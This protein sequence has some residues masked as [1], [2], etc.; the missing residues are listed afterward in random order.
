M[1]QN[2]EDILRK[3][4]GYDTFRP[5][6]REIIG[7][8]LDGRDTIAL[9]PTGGGKSLTYQVPALCSEGVAIVV[10]PLIALMK[11][12]V[13]TLRRLG[14][15]AVAINSAMS[16]REI[17]IALD[18]CVY[19]DVKLL[20][21]APERIDTVIFRQRVRKMNVSLIAIDEAHCI[22][23]WGYDFRPSYLKISTLRDLLPGVPVLAVTATATSVVLEDIAKYLNLDSA[24]VIRASFARDNLRFMVRRAEN[25]YEY[26]LRI[27]NSLPGSGIIYAR[28]RS[29]TEQIA[30]VLK[31]CSVSVDFYHAGLNFKIR[32]LKQNDWMSGRTRIVVAT[33]AFGMGIDKSDVRFV[34]HHQIPDS[35]EAYYQEA[36]RAGRDGKLSYAVLLYNDS[37]SGSAR[38][39]IEMEY[40][41][42]DKIKEIYQALFNYLQI[43]IGGGKD[44]IYDFNLGEFA[45][46]FKV[47]SLT[48][49]NAI[50]ILELN[51][52]MVLTDESEHSTRVMFRIGR[53]ELYRVQVDRADLDGV[54]KA[55]LRGYTGLFSQFTAIDETYLARVSGYSER[56][57]VE[58]LLELSRMKIISYIPRRTSP[59]LS[60]NEERLPIGDVTISPQTY[61]LRREQSE[62]R[63]AAVVDYA[64]QTTQCRSVVLREYFDEQNV[65]PCGTCDICLER[66]KAGLPLYQQHEAFEAVERQILELVATGNHD[67]HSLMSNLHVRASVALSAIRRVISQG[68]ILHLAN[69]KFKSVIR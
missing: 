48:A 35:I 41:P 60:F 57:I 44:E 59:L 6:Q 25:K 42:I 66:K 8:V 22:S 16:F 54:L 3:V 55:I 18:N 33:N 15:W 14:V 62:L 47:F 43:S 38:Q 37:D 7:R 36:G 10:T 46:R 65:P 52:Y 23:Q 53:D 32:S 50:K 9:L 39:R 19:G 63:S 5:L 34:I 51:G 67:L 20:Y 45:A 64:S 68:K 30:L 21:I 26:I 31:Q 40:P 4:W 58:V 24:E 27:V 69:G 1:V 11:D 17:D 61:T 2:P 49:Y 28:T 12:Q 13:E 56:H 29:E